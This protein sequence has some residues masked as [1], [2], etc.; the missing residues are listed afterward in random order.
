MPDPHFPFSNSHFSF[1]NPHFS[2]K[3]SNDGNN[4]AWHVKY[5]LYH[6]YFV[7]LSLPY[8]AL[9]LPRIYLNCKLQMPYQNTCENILSVCRETCSIS[10]RIITKLTRIDVRWAPN[11][12]HADS[13]SFQLFLSLKCL[14][15]APLNKILHL[16]K[17]V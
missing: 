13:A 1:S 3:S 15:N 10:I 12:L 9:S 14:Y 7:G 2:F 16:E 5:Q 17:K 4:L 8:S 11:L 6:V